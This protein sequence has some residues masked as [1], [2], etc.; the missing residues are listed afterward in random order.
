M[1]DDI[2]IIII[3]LLCMLNVITYIKFVSGNMK[4]RYN[5]TNNSFI[6]DKNMFPTF[7]LQNSNSKINC[8]VYTFK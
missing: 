5:I 8:I 3:L 7:I 1:L 4:T 6:Y 2:T